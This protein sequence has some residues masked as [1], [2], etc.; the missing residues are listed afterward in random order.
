MNFFLKT[1]LNF[2]FKFHSVY[3]VNTANEAVTGSSSTQAQ[4]TGDYS[5][6]IEE[7]IRTVL[8]LRSV[9]SNVKIVI[10][11]HWDTILSVIGAALKENGIEFRKKSTLFYQSIEQFK[12]RV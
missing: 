7:I 10:F 12:V 4:V 6:K 8:Q 1:Y 11:S 9:D 3:Y 2:F 5:S